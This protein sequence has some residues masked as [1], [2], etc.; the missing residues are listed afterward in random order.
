VPHF[1]KSGEEL[2][3]WAGKGLEGVQKQEGGSYQ[4][5]EPAG[6]THGL[7]RPQAAT[8]STAV[9]D[10]VCVG[11]DSELRRWWAR[12]TTG[13]S[14]K[15]VGVASPS[16]FR[17]SY[18]EKIFLVCCFSLLDLEFFLHLLCVCIRHIE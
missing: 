1:P 18:Q 5:R 4:I 16:S 13:G 10:E 14:A 12:A 9:E 11:E 2:C 3:N 8:Q 15:E 17:F 6:G 7:R